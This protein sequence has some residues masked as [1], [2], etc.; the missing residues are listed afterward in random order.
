[1]TFLF[2]TGNAALNALKNIVL[3]YHWKA[4]VF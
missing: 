3:I 2:L 1:M 4:K